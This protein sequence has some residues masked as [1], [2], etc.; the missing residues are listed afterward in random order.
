MNLQTMHTLESTADRHSIET[1]LSA[2]TPSDQH[3]WGKMSVHEML[4]H[5]CDSYQL[6]L[7]EK[8]ASLATGFLQRRVVKWIALNVP[9]QWPKGMPTRP[10]M[11]QGA[12]GT[13]P[14]NFEEDRQKLLS[15]LNDRA[16]S[17]FQ[18]LKKRVHQVL[19]RG[20]GAT[21]HGRSWPSCSCQE[22]AR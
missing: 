16:K 6:A 14:A 12:G 19:R 8:T 13:V 21:V 20:F 11:K 4:C 1:R 18:V 22:P 2:L 3:L 5:L 17:V 15:V 7:G 9:L 10:E